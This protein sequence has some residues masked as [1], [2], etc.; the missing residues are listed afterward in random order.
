MTTGTTTYWCVFF[1]LNRSFYPPTPSTTS[2][3]ADS[4]IL[5]KHKFCGHNTTPQRY[6]TVYAASRVDIAMACHRAG[7]DRTTHTHYMKKKK[8]KKQKANKKKSEKSVVPP[9]EGEVAD[10]TETIPRHINIIRGRPENQG[11][12]QA[13]RSTKKTRT[14]SALQAAAAV[15][16]TNNIARFSLLVRL[17]PC[18]PVRRSRPAFVNHTPTPE[19]VPQTVVRNKQSRLVIHP[20]RKTPAIRTRK[21]KYKVSIRKSRG[22]KTQKRQGK[23]RNITFEPAAA[24]GGTS[25]MGMLH[26]LV[27]LVP[28]YPVCRLLPTFAHRRFPSTPVPPLA[29][30]SLIGFPSTPPVARPPPSPWGTTHGGCTALPTQLCLILVPLHYEPFG[31]FKDPPAPL[32]RLFCCSGPQRGLNFKHQGGVFRWSFDSS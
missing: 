7:Y 32:P 18:Y 9:C 17:A 6:Y 26:L 4:S 23:Q 14:I 2:V 13:N 11:K 29:P 20:R 21:K 5:E 12:R 25:G 22:I 15:C 28:C 3:G 24:V 31:C 19:K 10:N 16:G 1:T 30:V 27:G 8:R